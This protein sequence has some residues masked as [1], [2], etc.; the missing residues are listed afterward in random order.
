MVLMGNDYCVPQMDENGSA[1]L[2]P[3][4]VQFAGVNAEE[5]ASAAASAAEQQP[6]EVFDPSKV[7]FVLFSAPS[8]AGRGEGCKQ[9]ILAFHRAFLLP[10]WNGLIFLVSPHSTGLGSH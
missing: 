2:M 4:D 5:R 10:S 1:I 3:E 6:V 7:L 8:N 9:H